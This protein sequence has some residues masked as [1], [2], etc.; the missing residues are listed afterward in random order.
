M[1][2]CGVL[3]CGELVLCCDVKCCD[4]KCCGECERGVTTYRVNIARVV[5]R[6]PIMCLTPKVKRVLSFPEGLP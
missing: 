2:C 1:L 4:V 6:D 3:C 5:E